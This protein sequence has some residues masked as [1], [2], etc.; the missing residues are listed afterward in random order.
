[1]HF[2]KEFHDNNTIVVSQPGDYVPGIT[3]F[4]NISSKVIYQ[5]HSIYV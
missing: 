2:L 1:M 4:R 3:V 5:S